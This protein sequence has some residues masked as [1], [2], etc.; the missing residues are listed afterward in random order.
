VDGEAGEEGPAADPFLSPQAGAG[1]NA[2]T[3]AAS[4]STEEPGLGNTILSFSSVWQSGEMLA[5]YMFG[6]EL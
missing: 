4:F 5:T 1:L 2:P 3:A 6:R